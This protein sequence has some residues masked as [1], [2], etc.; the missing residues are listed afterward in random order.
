MRSKGE[1]QADAGRLA[2]EVGALRAR[3]TAL[4]EELER[5]HSPPEPERSEMAENLRPPDV[6]FY[7]QGMLAIIDDDDLSEVETKLRDVATCSD[8]SLHATWR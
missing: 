4:I 3:C 6:S 5:D 8:E 7:L 1:I 2:D